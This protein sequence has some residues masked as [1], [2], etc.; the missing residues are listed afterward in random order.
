MQQKALNGIISRRRCRRCW[1]R[2]VVVGTKQNQ[3][4]LYECSTSVMKE[5][6]LVVIYCGNCHH[7]EYFQRH[8]KI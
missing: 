8:S 7:T 1:R 6:I 4:E 2:M 3:A 5:G